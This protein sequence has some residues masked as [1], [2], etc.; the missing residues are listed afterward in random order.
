M[1]RARFRMRHAL[2]RRT[3]PTNLETADGYLIAS[4]GYFPACD[5]TA[6]QVIQSILLALGEIFRFAETKPEEV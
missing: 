4:P 3:Y 2:T 1:H 5:A 6:V